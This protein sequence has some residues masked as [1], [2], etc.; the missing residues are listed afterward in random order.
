MRMQKK[1][2]KMRA[3]APSSPEMLKRQ[4]SQELEDGKTVQE[5]SGLLIRQEIDKLKTDQDKIL[6][7]IDTKKIALTDTLKLYIFGIQNH[8]GTQILERSPFERLL[9]AMPANV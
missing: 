5:D 3:A 9:K 4:N 8:L 1:Y 6:S 2:E 7:Q